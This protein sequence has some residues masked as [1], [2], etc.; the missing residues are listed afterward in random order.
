MT[1]PYATY[2]AKKP[3]E[4]FELDLWCMVLAVNSANKVIQ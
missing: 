4:S 2:D 3:G 1:N